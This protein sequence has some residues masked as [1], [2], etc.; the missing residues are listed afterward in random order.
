MFFK[1]RHSTGKMILHV[2]SS[3]DGVSIRMFLV[4]SVSNT[5]VRCACAACCRN[6]CVNWKRLPLQRRSGTSGVRWMRYSGPKTVPWRLTWTLTP[7]VCRPPAAH[8]SQC[9]TC[10]H[11]ALLYCCYSHPG[12]LANP[13]ACTLLGAAFL[14][15]AIEIVPVCVCVCARALCTCLECRS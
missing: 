15:P 2:P 5:C 13:P 9:H 7:Q 4:C 6:E 12:T 11:L 14:H 1:F 10:L 8:N 3:T